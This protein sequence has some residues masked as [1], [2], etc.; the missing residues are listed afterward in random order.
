MLNREEIHL[1]L[2]VIGG[3]AEKDN[4]ELQDVRL[5]IGSKIEDTYKLLRSYWFGYM[6]ID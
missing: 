4:L 1:L 6:R 2:D 3:Q 5:V